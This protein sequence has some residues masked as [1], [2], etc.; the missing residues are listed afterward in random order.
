MVLRRKKRNT[1]LI[2]ADIMVYRAATRAERA[3][4]WD[5]ETEL[6]TLH[7]DL[8][9]AKAFVQEEVDHLKHELGGSR[10]IL[11]FS[12]R[13]TFRH[14]LF[15]AYKAHR[16]KNRKPTC[17]PPLRAWAKAQWEH[18]QWPVLEA[19]DVLGILAQ[20]RRLPAPKIIVSDDHDL[21]SVPC[22]LYSPMHPERG[23]E[24]ISYA[25][26]RRHHLIQTLTGDSGD[27]YPGLPGVGPKRAEAIL[28]DGTWAEVVE[29]YEAKGLNEREALLQSRLAKILT[30]ALYN[31][32]SQEVTLWDPKKHK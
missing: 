6:W 2:D 25:A 26:A 9:E 5:E 10:V 23:V 8:Q 32:T 18:E 27:G 21:R 17:L 16:K 20:S 12:N 1:L 11:A 3:I 24:R 22:Q 14:E 31:Q 7:A 29:A 13:R 28:S 15:P 19:D 30:P 4:C